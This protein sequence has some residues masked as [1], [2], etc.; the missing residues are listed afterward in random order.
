MALGLGHGSY[1]VMKIIDLS[2]CR[3]LAN[4]GGPMPIRLY[5]FDGVAS[6]DR[7]YAGGVVANSSS[8]TTWGLISAHGGSTV[9]SYNDW[10]YITLE[11]SPQA[12]S[13]Y[14]YIKGFSV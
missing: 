13:V 9:G 3:V 6:G 7:I 14:L 2:T 12:R 4:S 10:P 11:G 5:R 8:I 1:L